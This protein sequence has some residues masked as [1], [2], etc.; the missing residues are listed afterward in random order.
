MGENNTKWKLNAD[1]EYKLSQALK[2]KL[3]L[4]AG[5][6]QDRVRVGED[7]YFLGGSGE[8]EIRF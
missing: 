7:H 3:G 4:E 8:V 5:Y 6:F 2:L 1:A